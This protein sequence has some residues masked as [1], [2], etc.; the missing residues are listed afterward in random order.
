MVA[1]AAAAA[2]AANPTADYR[3]FISTFSL[4]DTHNVDFYLFLSPPPLQ[5]VVIILLQEYFDT[6]D[7]IP[8]I[9]S[10]TIVNF[11]C[12]LHRQIR[13]KINISISISEMSANHAAEIEFFCH[14]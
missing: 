1:A 11:V 4:S 2:T 9:F 14:T 10:V 7:I 8:T 5:T 12:I 6:P 13:A 3:F